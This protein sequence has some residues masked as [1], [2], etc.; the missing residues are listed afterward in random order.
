MNFFDASLFQWSSEKTAELLPYLWICATIAAATVAAGFGWSRLALRSLA[1]VGF[2]PAAYLFFH[3]SSVVSPQGFTVFGS[4]FVTTPFSHLMGAGVSVLAWLA[5]LYAKSTDSDDHPEW[6]CVLGCSVLGMALLPTAQNWIAFFVYLETMSVC[7]YILAAFDRERERSLEGALK[8]LLLG[9]FASALFLMGVV[10][11]FGATKSFEITSYFSPAAGATIAN[12]FLILG[13]AA[14]IVAAMSFKVAL[15]P[16]HMWAAD[17]YQ[18]APTALAG[19]LAGATK[20]C[21]ISTLGVILYKTNLIQMTEIRTMVV[22]L[23]CWSILVGNVMAVA[24]IHLRRVLAYSSVAN[25]GYAFLGIGTQ[26]A[27]LTSVMIALFIYSVTVLLVFV[28]AE[29]LA[30]AAGRPAHSDVSLDE[31]GVASQKLCWT[32]KLMLSIGIFSLAGI[33]PL[34]GFFGK[35]LILKD[36]FMSGQSLGAAIMIFGSLLGLAYYLRIFVPMYFKKPEASLTATTGSAS[37]TLATSVAGYA[38]LIA[39][40]ACLAYFGTLYTQTSVIQGFFR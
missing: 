21:V 9:A 18:S 23:A 17:V 4:S 35:Y 29:K 39:L 36:A 34:P 30:M 20:L 3:Q 14:L 37:S 7:G 31:V 10:L 24:Q 38:A 8:Y 12:K 26:V 32:D 19:F 28:G 33:P 11:I 16:F 40:A 13:G 22:M 1:T 25:A 2:L 6:L 15:V 5:S 27:G